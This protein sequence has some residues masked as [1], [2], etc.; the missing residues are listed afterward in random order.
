MGNKEL[1]EIMIENGIIL[2]DIPRKVKCVYE[3]FYINK[4]PNGVIKYLEEFNRERQGLVKI[5]FLM[6][7]MRQLRIIRNARKHKIARK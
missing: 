2:R 5:D 6:V 3:K 7:L 1:E 4:Y